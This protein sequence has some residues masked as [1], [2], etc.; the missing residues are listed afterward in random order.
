MLLGRGD[1]VFP[2][3]ENVAMPSRSNG[4]YGMEHFFMKL[5]V[6]HVNVFWVWLGLLMVDNNISFPTCF[7]TFSGLLF[8]MS[9]LIIEIKFW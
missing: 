5:F 4:T 1:G 3:G 2:V 6:Y 7:G 8:C 9:S